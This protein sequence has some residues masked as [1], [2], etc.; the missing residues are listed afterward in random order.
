MRHSS[1][2]TVS[3]LDLFGKAIKPPARVLT[4]KKKN[5][6][7][8][9]LQGITH[10]TEALTKFRTGNL[11]RAERSTVAVSCFYSPVRHSV[12]EEE[13]NLFNKVSDLFSDPMPGS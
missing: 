13:E 5:K 8:A 2:T 9:L 4:E 7:K 10:Q 11:A 1:I 12:P 6:C 3:D